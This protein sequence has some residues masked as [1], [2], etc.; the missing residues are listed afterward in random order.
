MSNIQPH[1]VHGLRHTELNEDIGKPRVV[2]LKSFATK[3]T[4]YTGHFIPR[5]YGQFYTVGIISLWSA[6]AKPSSTECI[7]FIQFSMQA[8]PI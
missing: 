4:L 5:T 3:K 6:D 2:L 8:K 7:K 1:M